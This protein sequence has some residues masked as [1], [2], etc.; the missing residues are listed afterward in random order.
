MAST[1]DPD[2]LARRWLYKLLPYR[3]LDNLLNDIDFCPNSILQFLLDKCEVIGVEETGL[4]LYM[5]CNNK[6]TRF[7]LA[8]GDRQCEMSLKDMVK[9][10]RKVKERDIVDKRRAYA[11]IAFS[12]S[13]VVLSVFHNEPVR[14]GALYGIDMYLEAVWI[15][16]HYGWQTKIRPHL[17]PPY[18]FE[19]YVAV[20]RDWWL[21]TVATLLYAFEECGVKRSIDIWMRG[22]ELGLKEA[23]VLALFIDKNVLS[24]IDEMLMDV[25]NI[26][27]NAF[28]SLI[29][30]SHLASRAFERS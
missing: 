7:Q 5:M 4:Y 30:T 10:V 19:V 11:T 21:D 15:S 22:K 16:T 14:L 20:V 28:K 17:F 26:F 27:I 1:V 29:S 12:G 6:L 8:V 23:G 3:Y 24:L 2:E 13:G 18:E 25:S 9:D